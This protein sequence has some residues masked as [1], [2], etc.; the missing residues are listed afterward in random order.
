MWAFSRNTWNPVWRMEESGRVEQERRR[1]GEL[2][3][4]RILVDHIAHPKCKQSKRSK[5][6]RKTIISNECI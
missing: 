4:N 6:E 2:R 1:M 3:T 5:A